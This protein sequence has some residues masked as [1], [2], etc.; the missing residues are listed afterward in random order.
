MTLQAGVSSA[1]PLSTLSSLTGKGPLVWPAQ[2]APL[3][4]FGLIRSSVLR[5]DANGSSMQIR[6]LRI[7]QRPE[8]ATL[9]LRL[10]TELWKAGDTCCAP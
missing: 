1:V 3:H 9:C 10:L 6:K 2:L 7:S 5:G 4:T 8:D